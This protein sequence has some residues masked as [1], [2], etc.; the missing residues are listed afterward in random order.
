LNIGV[1]PDGKMVELPEGGGPFLPF[2]FSGALG[3]MPF[4]VWLY[5]AIEELPLAAEEAHD[6]KRDM[7]KGLLLGLHSSTSVISGFFPRS[8]SERLISTSSAKTTAGMTESEVSLM[9]MSAA[10]RRSR[11]D[12]SPAAHASFSRALLAAR[13]DQIGSARACVRLRARGPGVGRTTAA[14]HH[15][16]ARSASPGAGSPAR[17]ASARGASA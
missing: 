13:P 8:S 15:G 9:T 3:A 5:L 6:P 17:A 12:T 2:G 10:T 7:P 16:S 4:A 11:T 1:G 14:G